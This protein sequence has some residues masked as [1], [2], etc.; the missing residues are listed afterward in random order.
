VWAIARRDHDIV[1][2]QE[3]L[4]LGYHRKAIEHRVA[5]G[6]LHR[7]ARGVY[8]VGSPHLTRRGELMVA[9]KR[10]G[11]G[12]VLSH[13][14]A[15][16]HWGIWR[17]EPSQIHVTVPRERNPRVGGIVVSRRDLRPDAATSHHRVPVT[18][19]LQT[20]IDCAPNRST[21]EV[22][23]M[24]N[25]ADARNLL[26]ADVLHEALED[27]TEPGAVRMRGILDAE[28]F[29][30]TESALEQAFVPIALR[31]GLGKPLT[32]YEIAGYRLDF[33]FPE[34]KLAVEVDGLTYHRTPLEQRRDLEK[35]HALAALG[36]TC[37]RFSTWQ[38]VRSPDYVERNVRPP[39][40]TPGRPRAA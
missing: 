20:L 24:I 23:R 6:R 9:I 12:T 17:I 39:A 30:L 22:E 34:D 18:T 19:V 27:R 1:S 38:V 7:Q 13:L 28:A 5:S 35:E 25:Q 26:R 36:I 15:A 16:V 40:R 32:Q 33:Y 3:L 29:V 11:P 4:A 21:R 8:S 10:C 2:R 14:T 31:A 37:R